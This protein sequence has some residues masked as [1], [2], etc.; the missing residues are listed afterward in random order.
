MSPPVI[1]FDGVCGLCSRFVD[2]V[3]RSDHDRVFRFAPL[4]GETARR[5]I[6]GLTSEA[7][8]W[9]VVY[10]DG[11]ERLERSDAIFAICRRLG[12]VWRLLS[13]GVYVP[14]PVREGLYRWVARNRYHWFGRRDSCRLPNLQEQDRFLP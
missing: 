13:L 4:Q 6:P 10:L 14:R 2:A 3:L 5:A 7:G 11:Q 8:S 1:F 9:S 12:G